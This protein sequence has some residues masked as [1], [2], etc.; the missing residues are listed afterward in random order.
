MI[1]ALPLSGSNTLRFRISGPV[2]FMGEYDGFT[3]TQFVPIWAALRYRRP[4]FARIRI[5][6][7]P[8]SDVPY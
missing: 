4:M 6:P 8:I 1:R 3:D 7:N 5:R 2:G